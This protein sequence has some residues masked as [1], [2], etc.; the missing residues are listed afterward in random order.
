MLIDAAGRAA[1][2]GRPSQRRAFDRLVAVVGM[3]VCEGGSPPDR[4]TWTESAR[5]GW[6]YTSALPGGGLVAAYFTDSDLLRAG[7]GK[8]RCRWDALLRETRGTLDRLAGAQPWASSSV[9]SAFSGL[10]SP[11]AGN[12]WLV[13]GDAAHT[14]DPLSSQ[15][16][17]WLLSRGSRP[18][19]RYWTQTPTPPS[20]GN[21]DGIVRRYHDYLRTGGCSTPA[22]VAGRSPRSG[23]GGG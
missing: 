2:P 22:N 13:V 18:P 20:R 7:P 8:R 4:R 15:G 3:F 23:A 14:L 10:A 19:K 5:D 12:G 9:I 1:W 17:V 21:A 6:W 11:V 16:I